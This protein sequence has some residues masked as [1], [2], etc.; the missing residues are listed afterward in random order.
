MQTFVTIDK[1]QIFARHGVLE[2]E[3][4]TGNMFEVSVTL[5][6]DFVEA[7]ESDD[8]NK[9]LNYAELTELIVEIMK[10]TRKLIETVAVDMQ[11]A[12]MARWPEV[13][14]GTLSITKLHPP[15]PAPTPQA[16]VTLKW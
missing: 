2:Q 9:T 8:L 4:I 7:A 15:I 6:Y 11:R 13:K 1:L 12:I 16:T 3:A 14:S 10:N 5:E